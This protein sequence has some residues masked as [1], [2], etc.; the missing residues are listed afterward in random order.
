MTEPNSKADYEISKLDAEIARSK[1]LQALLEDTQRT[2]YT[3][4]SWTAP[5][6]VYSEKSKR[7]YVSISFVAMLVIIYAVLTANWILILTVISL[8]LVLFALNSIPPYNTKNVITNQGLKQNDRLIPWNEIDSFW[9]T[10]RSKFVLINFEL[11]NINS[12]TT[13]RMILLGG[14]ADIKKIVTYLVQ[15]VDYLSAQE[16]PQGPISTLLQGEYQPLLGYLESDDILTLDP[17]DAPEVLRSRES[18]AKAA[19][20]D[21]RSTIPVSQ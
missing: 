6:R 16:A 1:K 17:K 9:V 20:E 7:W 14:E 21:A 15:R 19:E 18:A 11:L 3:V 5:E 8:V 13:S 2:L 4:Y 12:G 10:I